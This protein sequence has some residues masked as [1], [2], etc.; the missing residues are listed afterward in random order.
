LTEE[1]PRFPAWHRFMNSA[2]ATVITL[3]RKLDLIASDVAALEP[4]IAALVE[5]VPEWADLF[6]YARENPRTLPRLVE[7]ARCL[8]DEQAGRIE[9]GWE[10]EYFRRRW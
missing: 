9:P 7:F 3:L 6:E 5:E 10:D 4:E 2:R 1:Q 8:A